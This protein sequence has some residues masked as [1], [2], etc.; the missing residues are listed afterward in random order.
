MRH[1]LVA[2]FVA[3][4]AAGSASAQAEFP[5]R[6]R[7]IDSGGLNG[8]TD[9]GDMLLLANVTDSGSSDPAQQPLLTIRGTITFRDDVD[10]FLIRIT[11]PAAFSASTFGPAGNS[12]SGDTVLGLFSDT[13]V[14][15]SWN[16]NRP[17]NATSTL[18]TIIGTELVSGGH[19]PGL[20]YLAVARNDLGFGGTFQAG[21]LDSMGNSI[22]PFT[23]PPP[24]NGSANDR[25]MQFGPTVPGTVLAGWRTQTGGFQPFNLNY[26][27]NLVGAEFAIPTPGAAG[28]LAL[29]GVA[30]L[31]RRR[32]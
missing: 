5:N 16:D 23:D 15:I 1:M 28:L 32:A 18:S 8:L 26:N 27:I 3:L 6:W 13:G 19:G 14:A 29:A 25:R 11:N 30:T 12:S 24:A 21:A 9:A 2:S 20:Y 4:A 17:E 7:E 10:M 31:R 22:F